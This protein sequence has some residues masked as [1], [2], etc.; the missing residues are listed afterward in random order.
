MRRMG[1]TLW[2]VALASIAGAAQAQPPICPGERC[3]VGD[4]CWNLQ[5]ERGTCAEKSAVVGGPIGAGVQQGLEAREPQ[6]VEKICYCDTSGSGWTGFSRSQVFY[7][8]GLMA[9]AG[10]VPLFLRRRPH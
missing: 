8:G 7:G 5:F 10:L 1:V 9:L 6:E 2:I 4:E 3:P